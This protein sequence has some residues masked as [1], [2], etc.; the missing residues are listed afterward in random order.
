MIELRKK[1]IEDFMG[2]Y[3]DYWQFMYLPSNLRIKKK[4]R[5]FMIHTLTL[6]AK[7]MDV[8]SQEYVQEMVVR[9][10]LKS[11]TEIY[12][13]RARLKRKGFLTDD[14]GPLRLP[15]ALN[16]T[17]VPETMYFRFK[18]ECE[19]PTIKKV[20]QHDES[21]KLPD[22]EQS[23]DAEK[24]PVVE[25]E[26][27][28]VHVELPIK[29]TPQEEASGDPLRSISQLA[30]GMAEQ[31]RNEIDIP[32]PPPKREQP[33]PETEGFNIPPLSIRARRGA[34]YSSEEYQ[35]FN[36]QRDQSKL[37]P[38]PGMEQ[39]MDSG[40][41]YGD[42][43]GEDNQHDRAGIPLPGSVRKGTGAHVRKSIID[44]DD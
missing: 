22:Y 25:H 11:N 40:Q 27:V 29:R 42:G 7:G 37:P 24:P 21:P 3:I 5:D 15:K 8:S 38:I 30:R 39:P 41:G 9:M 44:L 28:G 31:V 20:K 35:N 23:S 34:G 10:N 19:E 2:L 32:E 43:I 12:N 18:V 13:Y 6:N 26:E 17:E 1:T 36:R 16:I 33:E 4:E 14:N